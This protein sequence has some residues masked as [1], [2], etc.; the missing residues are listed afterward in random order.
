LVLEAIS[1]LRTV[2]VK[3]ESVLRDRNLNNYTQNI[4]W[5][6]TPKIKYLPW[7]KDGGKGSCS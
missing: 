4:S 2:L 3:A 6:S 7:P 5:A 1:L